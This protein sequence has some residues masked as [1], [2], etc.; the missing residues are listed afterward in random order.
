MRTIYVKWF[1]FGSHLQLQVPICMRRGDGQ[2][3]EPVV[4]SSLLNTLQNIAVQCSQG[5]RDIK[6]LMAWYHCY[7]ESCNKSGKSLVMANRNSRRHFFTSRVQF[8]QI[9]QFKSQ[10]S[11][12]FNFTGPILYKVPIW[13]PLH[14]KGHKITI[15]RIWSSHLKNVLR[16]PC[17]L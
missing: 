12:F 5:T 6:R 13:F 7:R 16:Q 3:P 17:I 2:Q 14:Q 8:R 10:R 15:I 9:L 1:S 4:L 11:P